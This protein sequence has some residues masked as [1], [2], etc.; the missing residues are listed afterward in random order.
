MTQLREVTLGYSPYGIA[1]ENG[2][3]IVV[4]YANSKLHWYD[5]KFTQQREV[6]LGYSPIGIAIENGAYI[7]VDYANSKLH[8]YDN[9]F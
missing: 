8:W 9:K 4:D 3:Y 5:N 1:I 2:G 6:T 7:V